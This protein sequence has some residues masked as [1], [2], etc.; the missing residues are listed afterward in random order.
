M[1]RY[2]SHKCP[3]WLG[4]DLTLGVLPGFQVALGRGAASLLLRVGLVRGCESAPVSLANVRLLRP[5]SLLPSCQSHSQ[6][7]S[8]LGIFL[9][10]L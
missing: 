4:G 2:F 1:Y 8:S 6:S 7:F 9:F 5:P 10:S 3:Y